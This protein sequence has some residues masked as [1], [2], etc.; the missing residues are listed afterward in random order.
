MFRTFKILIVNNLLTFFLFISSHSYI[1]SITLSYVYLY[2][3]VLHLAKL[4]KKIAP[5][6]SF[7]LLDLWYLIKITHNEAFHV[8][9]FLNLLCDF[10]TNFKIIFKINNVK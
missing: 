2:H 8:S 4:I 3:D 10:W 7:V 6:Y 9:M 1:L 5:I